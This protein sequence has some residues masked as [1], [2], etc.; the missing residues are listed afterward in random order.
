MAHLSTATPNQ[1]FG[2]FVDT[3]V[4]K[5]IRIRDE[6]D[7]PL[8]FPS[9]SEAEKAVARLTIRR[10]QA[11]LDGHISFEDAMRMPEYYE[12]I[13]HSS[14]TRSLAPSLRSSV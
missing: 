2:I 4:R 8:A 7:Q 5:K 11:F 6:N 1:R 12:E 13:S 9:E 10:I 14:R 3:P